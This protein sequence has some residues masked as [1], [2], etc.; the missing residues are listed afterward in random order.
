M[1]RHDWYRAGVGKFS[2]SEEKGKGKGEDGG[3]V[4]QGA[5]EGDGTISMYCE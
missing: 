3:R 1:C 2:F 4:V 5:E